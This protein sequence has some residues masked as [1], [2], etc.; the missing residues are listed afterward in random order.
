[1][2]AVRRRPPA[3]RHRSERQG[4]LS[5]DHRD[6]RQAGVPSAHV[7]LRLSARRRAAALVLAAAVR[8]VLAPAAAGYQP[9]FAHPSQAFDVPF[10]GRPSR[11][12]V[13]SPPPPRF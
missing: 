12:H 8:L 13:L 9:V 7:P 1:M 11:V 5:C 3:H 2:A 4:T 10:T 6:P